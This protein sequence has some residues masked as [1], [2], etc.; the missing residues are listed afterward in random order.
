MTHAEVTRLPVAFSGAKS[1]NGPLVVVGGVEGQVGWDEFAAIRLPSGEVRRGLVLE[2]HHDLAIVQLLQGTSGIDPATVSVSF[3]GRP[4]EIPVGDGWLGRVWNG[5]GEPL[6][7]GPPMLA[8]ATSA[9]NGSPINPTAREVPSDPILTGISVIDG[10]VTL[11]RGQKLPIF[12]SAG[13]PHL[14]LAAQLAAQASAGGAPFKVVFAAMGLPHADA[15][16][17]RDVL[18]ARSTAGDLA[19]FLDL[20]DDPVVQR[21]LTPRIALTVAEYLAFERGQHV[22]V[23][24]ADMTSY[25]EAVRE[26]SAA[27]GEMPG[28]RAYPS[29]LYSDLASL[30]ERCGRIRG[31]PGSLT[32]VPVLTM[33]AND[34]THPVP[35]LTGYITEGQIVLEPELNQAGIY[36]PVDVLNSLSRMMRKGTG[37]GLTRADH[38]AL[39]AQTIAAISRSR[40]SRDLSDL[41]GAAA[42]TDTD[43][44][45]LAFADAFTTQFVKQ[46]VTETRSLDET[47]RLAWQVVSILPRRE[48]TM[49]SAADLDKYDVNG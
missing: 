33:P 41:I 9:V 35:D 19:L 44:S 27:R 18:E 38:P 32:L 34:I 45:Y 1:A 25:C 48:L 7:G 14:E 36:P 13:L 5:M 21:I 43:R 20:A 39:A 16:T 23:V 10:L 29:Y 11:V 28:R 31:K 17:I 30:Y 46:G 42:L 22:L 6:D 2:I 37:A 47:L 15:A 12:S 40:Q 24:L 26:V 49:I 3:D 4:L 8:A